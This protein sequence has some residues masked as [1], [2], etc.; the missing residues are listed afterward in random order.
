MLTEIGVAIE[1]K[2]F[3]RVKTLVETIIEKHKDTFSFDHLHADNTFKLLWESMFSCLATD[4]T[5]ITHKQCLACI[6][7]LS[8]DKT[9]LNKIITEEHVNILLRNANLLD[10]SSCVFLTSENNDIVVE[11]L[12]CLCNI[13]YQCEKV[14]L[15]CCA[16]NTVNCL[17]LRLRIYF[18]CNVPYDIKYFDVRLLFLLTAF[19]KAIRLKITEELHGLTYLMELLDNIL[20]NSIEETSKTKQPDLHAEN[21]TLSCEVLKVLFNLTVNT[22][23]DRSDDN[24]DDDDYSVWIR[25]VSILRDFIVTSTFVP[26]D[27]DN[28]VSNV[29][30]LLTN[31]PAGCLD[32]LTIKNHWCNVE[33]LKVIV[34]FLDDRLSGS[35]VLYEN[36]SPVLLVLLNGSKAIATFRR[37]VR[38]RILPPLKDIMNRPEQGNS[39]RNKLC[40]LLTT[41]NVGL[42]DLVAE[43][44]FVLCK[45]NVGRMIKYTGFGNAAGLFANLGLLNK[46]P[47][48]DYSS[49]SEDSDTE[50]YLKYKDQINPVLGCYEPPKPNPFECMS[51]EQQ[52]HEVMQLVCKMDK[53]TREGVIQPCKIGDDGRPK[54]IEHVLQLQ[55][56]LLS[57]FNNVKNKDNPN[58]ESD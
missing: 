58:D 26:L 41:P 53:L 57:H 24:D 45:E 50:E 14:Q 19:N 11:G 10:E 44:L 3:E 30:N 7:L 5:K 35:N 34:D 49:N 12:K 18:E 27:R 20:H 13:V 54:P 32:Q 2:D 40:R 28:I 55:E 51:D 39:L 21:V 38:H 47:N 37:S 29:V 33:A 17:I 23:F 16:N 6:R 31:V 8:R 43:L 15:L 56:E 22:N 1:N 52:E 36:V 42:R 46:T 9:H 25:L 4:N 48:P